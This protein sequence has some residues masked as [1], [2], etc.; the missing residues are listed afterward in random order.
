MQDIN[1]SVGFSPCIFIERE[2]KR[3][4][5]EREE[6]ETR[7]D[8][9]GGYECRSVPADWIEQH[10]GKQDEANETSDRC[11]KAPPGFRAVP[12]L[13]DPPTN[14]SSV[15]FNSLSIYVAPPDPFFGFCSENI[16]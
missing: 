12:N 2:R 6:E 7:K 1:T 4:E 3:G 5:K 14:V 16:D 13:C 8:V 11:S 15:C 9:P 10:L